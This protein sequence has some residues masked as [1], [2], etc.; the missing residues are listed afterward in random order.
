[1]KNN[2]TLLLSAFTL[3]FLIAVVGLKAQSVLTLENGTTLGI[4]SGSD[5][6]A[7]I[8][9]GRNNLYGSGTICSG[10]MTV[11]IISSNV[12]PEKFE[13]FQNFPNPFNPATFIKFQLPEKSSVN[14]KVY[15]QTG[16]ETASLFEGEYE[17]GFY[18]VAFDGAGLASGIY[19]FRIEAHSLSQTK[20]GFIKTLKMSLIK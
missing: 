8:I 12:T 20:S 18:S 16:R 2:I 11:Q 17:Q 19:Y 10:P 15:D 6:C 4:F 7:N 9:N 13:I 3:F 5:L 14:I 1:M